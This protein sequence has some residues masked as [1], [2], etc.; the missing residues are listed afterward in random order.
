VG[1]GLTGC[2]FSVE[3]AIQY[4]CVLAQF[5]AV[6]FFLTRIS[7]KSLKK[8]IMFSYLPFGFVSLLYGDMFRVEIVIAT[9]LYNYSCMF[10]GYLLQIWYGLAFQI[11][12][13]HGQP[14]T[15]G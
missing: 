10:K 15:L 12:R 4:Q 1:S 11:P 14:K 5:P 9:Y 8:Q 2:F 3:L 7:E 13:S 6:P